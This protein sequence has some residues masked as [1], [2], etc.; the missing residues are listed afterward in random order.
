MSELF[1]TKE[2]G[3][4]LKLRPETVLR[5]VGKGEIPAIRIGGHFRFD[6]EQIDEWLCH[7][8]TS[9]KRILVIDAEET[10]RHLFKETLEAN[11]Y[12][13]ITTD[14]GTK[15]LELVKSWNFDLIFVDLKMPGLNGVETFRQI[16]EI[17]DSVPVVIITGYPISGL[18]EK[19]LEQGPF[20]VMKKPLGV[21]DI[22]RSADSYLRGVK[23][24][25]K[26]TEGFQ[27]LGYIS[28]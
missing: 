22:R 17:N 6:K 28:S 15:A 13:V 10:I 16:R 26:L 23:A 18:M 8:S 21:L 9:K 24:K 14:D 2:I 11:S 4:Y 1:T 7:K 20:G 3:E 25:D 27:Q 12:H 5:K 19:A